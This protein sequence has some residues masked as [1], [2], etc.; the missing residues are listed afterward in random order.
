MAEI[1]VRK[2]RFSFEDL[3]LA[4]PADEINEILPSLSVR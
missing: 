4:R 3:D 1:T 2:I